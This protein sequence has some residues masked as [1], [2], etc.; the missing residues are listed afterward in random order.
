MFCDVVF[1]TFF[2]DI[3]VALGKPMLHWS[4]ANCLVATAAPAQTWTRVRLGLIDL[5][6]RKSCVVRPASLPKCA[7]VSFIVS[8][9]VI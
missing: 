8:V 9:C 5:A 1:V 4:R 3:V 6:P 2:R 7:M